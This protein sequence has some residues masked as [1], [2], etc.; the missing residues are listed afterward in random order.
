MTCECTACGEIFKSETGFDKHRTGKYTIPSTRKCLT[1]RQMINK[2]MIKKE[3]YWITSEYTFK[4][5]LR[6]V[7]PSK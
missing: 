6:D 2:G 7:Q 5:S 4:P 3:G 1:K